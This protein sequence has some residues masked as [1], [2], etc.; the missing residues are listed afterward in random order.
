[1]KLSKRQMIVMALLLQIAVLYGYYRYNS[2]KTAWLHSH[3]SAMKFKTRVNVENF[4]DLGVQIRFK[5]PPSEL[6]VKQMND[7]KNQYAIRH[8][9]YLSE[10]SREDDEH[11]YSMMCD[12]QSL[13]YNEM[14]IPELISGFNSINGMEITDSLV[15]E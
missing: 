4:P 14:A 12:F 15:I 11:L 10:I 2:S 1:M 9:A 3:S 6:L 8:N 13:S 5:V 7:F